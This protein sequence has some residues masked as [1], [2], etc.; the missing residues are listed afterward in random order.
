ME[1]NSE[2]NNNVTPENVTNNESVTQEMPAVTDSTTVSENKATVEEK[3]LEPSV[4]TDGPIEIEEK[5]VDPGFVDRTTDPGV[6]GNIGP[7]KEE[8]PNQMVNEDLKKVEVNY[9]PPSKA[10]MVSLILF[11]IF[12]IAFIIFLPDITTMVNKLKEGEQEA[13]NT[14]ITTGRLVCTYSTNTTNLDKDYKLTFAFTDNKLD[15]LDFNLTTKG[16]PTLD[17]TTLDQLADECKLLK[18]FTASVEGVNITCDYAEGKLTEKQSFVY[19][20]LDAEALSSAYSEAGGTSPQY[21][22]G[23]D[24]DVIEKNMNASGY[25]CER[26]Q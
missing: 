17:A 8:V 3:P 13:E 12:L 15:R 23:Q 16:D 24:M 2:L 11:F 22:A 26:Q 19:A 10:K 7:V 5:T 14:K 21:V 1:N 25:S 20:D 6:I 18:Q 4:S 9:T